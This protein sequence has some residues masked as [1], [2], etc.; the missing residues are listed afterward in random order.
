MPVSYTS[1]AERRHQR[2]A[3][4]MRMTF[5]VRNA[6]NVRDERHPVQGEQVEKRLERVIRVTDG[7]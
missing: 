2:L 4:K 1:T 6:A 3:A 5:R 7:V